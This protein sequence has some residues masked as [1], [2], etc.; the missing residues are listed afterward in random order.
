MLSGNILHLSISFVCGK[1]LE[2]ENSRKNVAIYCRNFVIKEWRRAT[3]VLNDSNVV[4][5]KPD[6]LDRNY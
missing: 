1:D 3:D 5:K 4:G 6:E 2:Q